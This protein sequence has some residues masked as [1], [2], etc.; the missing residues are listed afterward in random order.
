MEY[1]SSSWT[2]IN[3]L[4]SPSCQSQPPPSSIPPSLLCDE[5]PLIDARLHEDE[6][7]RKRMKVSTTRFEETVSL[8]SLQAIKSIIEEHLSNTTVFIIDIDR[9]AAVRPL[10]QRLPD[11]IR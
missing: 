1:V 5:G 9:S 3:F 10:V 11:G 8:N 2:S 6:A 7:S 4:H